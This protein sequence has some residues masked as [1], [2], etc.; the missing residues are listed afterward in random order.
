MSLP[1]YQ[2]YNLK[3]AS[4]EDLEAFLKPDL[5]LRH[6]A[7][8]NLKVFTLDQQREL[9]GLI[10]NYYV[11]N[12]ISFKFPYPIYVM[13]EHESTIS[14]M[15]IVKETAELPK[16]YS[17]AESRMNVKETHLI[18]KNRLLQIEIKNT[19]SLA[20]ATGITKYGHYHREVVSLEDE[21]IYYKSIIAKLTKAK[22]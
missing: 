13:T 14:K 6:P 10:E 11:S 18:G 5:N 4:L 15:P 9:I 1:V 2:H 3:S 7:V 19:D 17:H 21:R 22:K 16:F 8:I 12:N 20:S